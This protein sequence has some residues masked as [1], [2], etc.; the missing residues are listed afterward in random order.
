M[1]TFMNFQYEVTKYQGQRSFSSE[2]MISKRKKELPIP[3]E[4]FL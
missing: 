3:E 2:V 4:I 1:G